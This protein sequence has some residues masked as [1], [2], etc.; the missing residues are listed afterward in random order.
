MV[1]SLP[2]KSQGRPI[3]LGRE[4]DK[5]VQEY[6]EATRNAGGVVNT[7]IVMAAAVGIM[8]SRNMTVL[9]S[10]GGHVEIT[11]SWAKSL[12]QRMGYVKQKCSNAG[13][14]SPTHFAEIKEV[15]L[16]DIQ[17]V[18]LMNEIPDELIVNWDQTGI[19]LVPTG[20]WTMHRA[21][22]K[23]I[24]ISNSDDKRQITAVLS[25]SITGEYLAPQLIFQGKTDRCH[26]KVTFPKGWDVWH[27]ENHWSNEDTM[28]RYIE[29]IIIPFFAHRRKALQLEETH[30][31][32][33]LARELCLARCIGITESVN[34]PDS[35]LLESIKS[36][37]FCS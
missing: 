19:Q 33:V 21:G 29:K 24:P 10:H 35:F 18:V 3:L 34:C 8:S 30:P 22:D 20:D 28:K 7:A 12:L 23:V 14:I 16:A 26:P 15:F 17:A 4:I 27:S 32:L 11:K 2:R 31:A 13:K 37:G 6:V 1:D 25:A 9:K 36:D 5:A